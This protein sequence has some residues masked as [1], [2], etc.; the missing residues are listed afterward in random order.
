M[1]ESRTTRRRFVVAA[2]TFSGL[3][4]ATIGVS[5]LRLGQSWAAGDD[6]DTL[7]AM[8]RLARL[9]YP[10]DA[11]PDSVYAEVLDQA[12]S[13]TAGSNGS[14]ARTLTAAEAALD[15]HGDGDFIFLDETTQI[16]ALRAVEHEGFF[17]AIQSAVGFRLYNHPAV[18]R[19]IGYEG[20]SWQQGGY[21]HRGAGEIDWLPEAD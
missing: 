2:I 5:V 7:A 21:L 20:P 10:H 16:E 9:L 3:T 15:A 6:G 4:T 8:T 14:F 12:L 17:A 13:A 1:G 19:H 11:V 18:W